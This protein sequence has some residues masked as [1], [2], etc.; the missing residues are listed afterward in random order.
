MSNSSGINNVNT[1]SQSENE[2]II[3]LNSG[4][5]KSEAIDKVEEMGYRALDFYARAGCNPG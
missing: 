4:L 5:S 3:H 2:M 1:E